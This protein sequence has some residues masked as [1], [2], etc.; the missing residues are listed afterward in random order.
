L[1]YTIDFENSGTGPVTEVLIVDT[2]PAFTQLEQA[3]EC[4]A[5]LPAGVI[6]CDVIEPSVVDN[7][8]GYEGT[9]Q[10]QFNGSL[11]SGA[12]GSVQ[13]DIRIQ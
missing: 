13:Y 11:P 3:V 10:W 4:P 6:S 1:R 12:G 9:V 7:V 5:S 8:S 2:T